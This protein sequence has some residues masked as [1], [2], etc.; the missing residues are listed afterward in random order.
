ME[1]LYLLILCLLMLS[2]IIGW[3]VKRT[4][5]NNRYIEKFE[6]R[7]IEYQ[8]LIIN[9]LSKDWTEKDWEKFWN[10]GTPITV[11]PKR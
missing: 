6:L 8:C 1:E 4:N 9:E 11:I 7:D 10:M 5:N 2:V 3:V